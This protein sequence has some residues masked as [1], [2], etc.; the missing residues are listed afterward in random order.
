MVRS[1]SHLDWNQI[2]LLC[3]FVIVTVCGCK[4]QNSEV[5]G[6]TRG[7]EGGRGIREKFE[8]KGA[9][10]KVFVDLSIGSW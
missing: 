2:P 10:D 9:S 5:D 4:R 6:E 7:S 1:P 8:K 3:S